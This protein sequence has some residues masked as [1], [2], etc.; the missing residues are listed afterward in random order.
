MGRN[1]S[2][3]YPAK[4][5][6]TIKEIVVALDN[7]LGEYDGWEQGSVSWG[8]SINGINVFNTIG[9]DPPAFGVSVSSDGMSSVTAFAIYIPVPDISIKNRELLQC[10]VTT[11]NSFDGAGMETFTNIVI[12]I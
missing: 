9:Y 12:E 10:F 4:A 6:G 1:Y 3:D 11:D 2:Y 7:S 5:D 8:I